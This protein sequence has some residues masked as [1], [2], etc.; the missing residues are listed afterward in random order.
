MSHFIGELFERYGL[1]DKLTV[2]NDGVDLRKFTGELGGLCLRHRLGVADGEILVGMAAGVTSIWKQHALFIEMAS[3]LAPLFPHVKFAVFG[4]E[5]AYHRNPVYNRAWDYYQDLK[6]QVNEARLGERF[7]WAGFCPNIP[8]MMD[9]MDVLV[10]PCDIEPFGRVAI[11]AMAAQ[12]PVVGP[13]QGGIAESVI[14]GETGFLVPPGDVA[15]F[16]DATARLIVDADL[17][18]W[19]GAAGRAHVAAHFSLEK[20]V[21]QVTDIYEQ[22]Y[23]A[24]QN[25][26]VARDTR[27]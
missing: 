8:Q 4:P 5:P 23:S 15:A 24:G 11:E 6:R 20:H 27:G 25:R 21:Q 10:H 3:R 14:D 1:T 18:R 16:A 19:M 2:V 13:N 7:I 17:R 9:A 12:R 26:P 22:V